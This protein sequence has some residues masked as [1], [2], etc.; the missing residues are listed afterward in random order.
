MEQSRP[1]TVLRFGFPAAI[2]AFLTFYF[3]SPYIVTLLILLGWGAFGQLIT[4]DDE[5]PGG[6]S[7]PEGDP[8]IARQAKT[9][10]TSTVAAFG[11]VFWLMCTYPHIKDFRW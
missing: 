2:A 6:W 7:N 3:H 8:A 1:A 11:V 4:L 9:W 5:L 10:L